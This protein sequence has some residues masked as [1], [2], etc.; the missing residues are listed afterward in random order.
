MREEEIAIATADYE[1]NQEVDLDQ[2]RQ[3]VQV[4]LEEA[5][6]EEHREVFDRA[7]ATQEG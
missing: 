2:I 5:F 3:D 6:I 4:E 7:R 1:C